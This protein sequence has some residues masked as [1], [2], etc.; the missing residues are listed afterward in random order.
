MDQNLGV[1][2]RTLD[3][4]VCPACHSADGL[5]LKNLQRSPHLPKPL[6]V[7]TM[8]EAARILKAIERGE[9]QAAEAMWRIL[10][11]AAR[12]CRRRSKRVT[13]GSMSWC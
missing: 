2:L 9:P 12:P 5:E 3:P 1:S 10:V 6:G 4:E 7:M 13:R 8:N 11:E